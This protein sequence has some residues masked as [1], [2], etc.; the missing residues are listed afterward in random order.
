LR[1]D[2]RCRTFG[3]GTESREGYAMERCRWLIALILVLVVAMLTACGGAEGGAGSG[4][5]AEPEAT[6]AGTVSGG[7]AGGRLRLA[8]TTSTEDS[9]LLTAIL[10]GFEEE[11]DA[12]VEV[13]AVGTG[14][15]LK[16]GENGDAD[17]V[18]VHARTL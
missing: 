5:T 17:V 12:R 10:P 8:T 3:G 4:A 9:G 15:A 14:Q 16:L 11:Y 2:L 1:Y 13:V 18:L 6:A 7:T